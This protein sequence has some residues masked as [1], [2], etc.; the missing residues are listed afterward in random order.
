VQTKA[1][2]DKA[3]QHNEAA[4][5]DHD[6]TGLQKND[7]VLDPAGLTLSPDLPA[8]YQTGQATA[9]KAQEILIAKDKRYI[10]P[11]G[12]QRQN[13][14]VAFAKKGMVVYGRAFD[15]V[16]VQSPLNLDDLKQVEEHLSSVVLLEIKSTKKQ[17]GSDFS[18]F[19]FSLTGGEVL[20]AQSLKDQFRFALV[21]T[22]TGHHEEL[23]LAQVFA[24]AKGIYPT[25]SIRL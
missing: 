20:V 18:G 5:T 11:S 8:I 14:L 15:M 24:R 17:V 13:L 21:N 23:T 4:M 25:W 6:D 9:K 16:K 1:E 3:F 2:L 22:S 10:I 19:F 7:T 12:R